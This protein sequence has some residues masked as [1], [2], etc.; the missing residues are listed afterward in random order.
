[1]ATPSDITDLDTVISNNS[2]A[3]TES[4]AVID[5]H[6]RALGGII[7]QHASKGSDIASSSTIVIPAEGSYFDVTGT[8]GITTISDTNQF[9]GRMFWLQFDGAVTLTHSASLLLPNNANITTTAGDVLGFVRQSSGVFRLITELSDTATT[10]AF[11]SI[12]VSDGA[13]IADADAKDI[14]KIQGTDL[15]EYAAVGIENVGSERYEAFFGGNSA[16]NDDISTKIVVSDGGTEAVAAYF[17]YGGFCY[18]YGDTTFDSSVTLADY[19]KVTPVTVA[20]LPAAA[21]AGVGARAFV[22]DAGGTIVFNGNVSGGGSY[23]MPVFSDGT[24]WKYG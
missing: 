18:F 17:T 23:P 5:D 19:I 15:Y 13:L 24:N 20:N 21:T 14:L 1:M 7:K 3:G 22:S 12:T 10:G 11:T 6:L 9:N 8:T 4:P 2:P 16:T